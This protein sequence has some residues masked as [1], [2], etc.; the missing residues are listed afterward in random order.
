MDIKIAIL[1]T[2]AL[3]AVLRLPTD[4]PTVSYGWLTRMSSAETS[5]NASD[6]GLACQQTVERSRWTRPELANRR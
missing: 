5:C 2:L 4:F 1:A 6:A 3:A